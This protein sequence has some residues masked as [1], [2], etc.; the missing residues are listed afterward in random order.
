MKRT[1]RNDL[2][3]IGFMQAQN[4]TNYV[5]S[6]RHPAAADDFMTAAHYQRIARTLEDG[7]FHMAFFDDRLAMPDIFGNDHEPTVRHGIRAVKMDVVPFVMAMGL[8]T[9]RL[10]LGATYSTTYHEPYHVARLFAT[11]DHVL[12]GR[13]AWNVVT[14]LNDGEAANFGADKLLEHDTR[15]ERA[16]EFIEVVLGHWNSWGEGA[17]TLDRATGEFADPA[18]VRRLD[19]RGKWFRSRGPFTVPRTPQGHPV[20]IQAGQSGR[21]KRFAAQWGEVVFAPYKSVESGR[22]QYRDLKDAVSDAGRNPDTVKIAPPIY[23]VVGETRALAEE[24][25]AMIDSLRADVDALSLISELTNFDFSKK[26]LDEPLSD[27]DLKAMSGQQA[28]T[29]RV[30]K[31]AGTPNPTPQDFIT[32]SRRGT[33]HE[34]PV[35]VGTGADVAD[36]LEDWYVNEACDGFVLA[37]TH[38]P[39]SYEDFV[40]LVVPELQRRGIYQKDYKGRTLRENLGLA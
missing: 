35:F 22:A 32:H 26:R 33:I 13:V 14:S 19:H 39:G 38:R 21:G 30:V 4:C 7:K 31:A 5:G 25:A 11:M 3:M 17:L 37:A 8:A 34:M 40:R 2:V 36:Q 9:T 16:D 18:L 28:I 12:G 1:K 27:E 15:Y 6:W 20:I 24:K 23:A 10:G 29:D